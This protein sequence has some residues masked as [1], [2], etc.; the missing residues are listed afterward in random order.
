VTTTIR[1]SPD[2]GHT[3]I[4]LLV[5]ETVGRQGP[6]R[7]SSLILFD[8]KMRIGDVPVRCGGI[9]GVTTE[10]AYREKGYSRRVLE[11][12]TAFMKESGYHLGALFGIPDYYSKFGYVSAFVSSESSVDTR[13]AEAVSARHRAAVARYKVRDFCPEDAPAVIGLYDTLTARRTGTVVRDPIKWQSLRPRGGWSPR[14]GTFVLLDGDR[15]VGYAAYRLD[16]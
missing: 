7:A 1:R 9:G 6:A 13:D 12:S 5:D 14:M 16:P 4:E 2:K 11:D 8:L 10:V 15:I 3:K